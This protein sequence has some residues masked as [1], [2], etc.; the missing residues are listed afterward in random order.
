MSAARSFVRKADP[1]RDLAVIDARAPRFNQTAVALVSL[2]ALLTGWWPLLGLMGAQLLIG[3]TFG[4]QYC[5]PCLF[6]FE[7]VQ[8]RFG[9][10]PLED[11]RAPRFANVLGAIF[12][13]SAAT[14]YAL[15]FEAIGFGLGAIVAAL[16]SLAVVSGICVGCEVYRLVA[17][18]R[19]VRGG[20]IDRIDLEQLGGIGGDRLVVLFTHP[21]CT[22]CQRVEPELAAR[23]TLLKVDVS[24]KRELAQKYGVTFV[25]L[26]FE[27][28]ADGTVVSRLH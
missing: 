11:A 26:A 28:S 8:P 12:L 6:Y 16:A 3:L 20:A 14:A 25:P 19:G 23:G 13:G 17:R 21:L 27:V 5:L 7:L 15:G 2:T 24:K 4:R 9:E 18:L 10:G 1:Y 22:D